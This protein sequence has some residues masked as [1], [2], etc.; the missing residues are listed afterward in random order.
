MGLSYHKVTG[1]LM[2]EGKSPRPPKRS[3]FKRVLRAFFYSLNGIR[4]AL[5]NEAAFRQEVAMG[6]VLIP[7]SILLPFE[8]TQRLLLNGLWLIL[9]SVELLNS[10][11]EAVVDLAS[12][13]YH[14]LAKRAKDMGSA[15]VLM[16]LTA[17]GVAWFFSLCPLVIDWLGK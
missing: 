3:D 1:E 7:L 8:L 15:A 6:I 11:I 10:A 5:R 9:L 4:N 17:L 16:V 2:G 12:P 13:E 14:E